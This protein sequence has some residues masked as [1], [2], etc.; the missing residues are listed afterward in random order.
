MEITEQPVDPAVDP[1]VDPAAERAVERAVE[2]AER[3]LRRAIQLDRE[4][5]LRQRRRRSR[6]ASL[7]GSPRT[8]ALARGLTDQVLRIDD[9]AVAATRF[10]SVVRDA[11]LTDLGTTDRLLLRAA[12]GLAPAAPRVVMPL[13]LRRLRDE[14]ADAV[15]LDREPEIGRYL[16]RRRAAEDGLRGN[17]NVLGEAILGPAEA[18]RRLTQIETVIARPEVDYVSV[19]ISAICSRINVLAF[20]ATV[21]TAGDALRRIYRA[22][23][24][25]RPRVFVNVDMEEY[26]DL[27]LTVAAYL[28]V[29]SEPEFLRLPTGIVIQA[30]LPDAHGVARELCEFARVRAGRGGAPIKVRLV[31]GANLA[32]E[33]VEAEMHGWLSAP[34]PTKA[35][36]DASYKLLLETLLDE[37]YDD[38]VRVGVASQNLFDVA[39]AIGLRE[40]LAGRGQAD[41]MG[42]EMLE[43]MAPGQ[44]RAIA[45]AVGEVVLYT[46]VVRPDDFTAAIA[47]LV[48]RL[49]ENTAPDN[50]LR[51]VFEI[52][53]GNEV[54][55][56]EA[57]RF[58]TAVRDRRSVSTDP[59]RGLDLVVAPGAADH[60][61]TFDSF[62]NAADTDLTSAAG[63]ARIAAAIDTAID[64]IR[65]REPGSTQR[66]VG[67]AEVN[68]AVHAGRTAQPAWAALPLPE[69]AR[70]VAA[71]GDVVARRRPEIIATMAHEAGKIVAEGDPEVSEAI[72]FARWY[73]AA[74]R[75]LEH[76]RSTGAPGR[77]GEA[78]T[79]S[80]IGVVVIAPPW[81]FP[82]AIALGGALAALAAGNA[83]VLKPAPQ[84]PLTGR[85]VAEC[86]WEAGIPRDAI[87][88]LRCAEDEAGR[89]L[90]T[91]DDVSAVVLTGARATA[92]LF[93]SWK[94]SL[95]LLG[96][97]SGKNS[98]VITAAA[99]LELAVKDLVRS[100]FG[101]AGQKCSAA[102]LAIVEE[103]VLTG[104]TFLDRLA[105]ATRNLVT[106]PARLATTDIGPLIEPPSDQ[107]R[108]ALGVLGAG[109]SWLVRPQ[110]LNEDETLWSPGIRTGVR[111]GSWFHLTECFGPVLGILAADDLDHAIELQNAPAYGLTAGLH[112]LDPGQIRQWVDRA[113]AGNLYVNRTTTGA[114]VGRQPFGGWKRSAV[115]PTAKAGGR[116]YV[117]AL[118]TW[119]EGAWGEGAWRE[120]AW[121]ADGAVQSVG[122][123]Y[124]AWATEHLDTES[125]AQGF[126]RAES[127]T[128][129]WRTLPGGVA[130]RAGR[131][132]GGTIDAA[133]VAAESARCRIV[134]S[135]PATHTEEDFAALVAGTGVD[136]LRLLG[137][138]SDLVREAA[139]RAGVV[140]DDRP[141]SSIPEVE[142]PRWLREQSVS[143]TRHRHG[144]LAHPEKPAGHR[145]APGS[146]H[147]PW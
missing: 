107:L 53:P 128:T 41:R 74:V 121:E 142:M 44:A 124:R 110:C 23:M 51:S 91:H 46:P 88:F 6:L 20:D 27:E 7:I 35:Q 111:P 119:G 132:A 43:G 38:S 129:R 36:V 80:G 33:L 94:P 113:E 45:E 127:N 96:E 32:M 143:I 11:S 78:P 141:L 66:R 134:V 13:V 34:Y 30:Y 15:V 79:D 86:C 8:A 58:R 14:S 49:D 75:Q 50:Y 28:R 101:H 108:R 116:H 90:I 117:D 59:R 102:S 54:F 21:E 112:S 70:L 138:A 100:A 73:A 47:Y 71:V 105:D 118:C 89:A 115:G 125:D 22:A 67:I 26:R 85:L 18:E 147:L 135:D 61:V 17:V 62:R 136:R 5:G 48:R 39:W 16:A 55:R 137:D 140:V 81:N 57:A 144:H 12:A 1:T 40:E 133:R 131:A 60:L 99:D 24:A 87:Q 98:M 139:H 3:L 65:D 56:R 37:R 2:C 25:A 114:I 83:V 126:L 68:A 97:T 10:S 106:G 93:H 103:S 29:L 4:T 122:A 63:R 95:R 77:S 69:R 82:F 31:K 64:T 84:T 42:F 109:E 130:V 76:R 146:S 104:T 92:D 19:K 145:E 120:G 52:A 123:G 72:D 9:P